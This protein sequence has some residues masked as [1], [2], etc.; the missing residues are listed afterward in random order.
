MSV[1]ETIE[2]PGFACGCLIQMQ[3]LWSPL[4]LFLHPL[5]KPNI[6]TNIPTAL[7]LHLPV[8]PRLPRQHG[9]ANKAVPLCRSRN[10]LSTSM[11]HDVRALSP[12]AQ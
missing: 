1:S 11:V 9:E 4:R 5:P 10:R 7:N 6:R 8:N 12:T 2:M 3:I